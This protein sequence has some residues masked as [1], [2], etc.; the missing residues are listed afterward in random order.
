ME[1]LPTVALLALGG[2]IAM[3][4]KGDGSEVTPALDASSIAA[5]LPG[6]EQLA[7]VRAQTLAIK[8]SASLTVDDVLTVASRGREAV[9]SGAIGVVL[10][11]G[12][13]TLEET[14]YL[15]DLVWDRGPPGRN[16]RHAQSGA[17]GRG[18]AGQSARRRARRN[19]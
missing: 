3:P 14:S 8:P 9:D 19:L 13:D 15:L 12:T 5:A 7:R 17:T 6:L 2:T 11:Q 18:W 10:T 16:R 1:H 4:A